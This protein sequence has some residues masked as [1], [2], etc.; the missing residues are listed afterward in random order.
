MRLSFHTYVDYSTTTNVRRAVQLEKV[1][2]IHPWRLFVATFEGILRTTTAVSTGKHEVAANQQKT[3][4][5]TH[6]RVLLPFRAST[7][8]PCNMITAVVVLDVRC[9]LL[10]SAQ[11]QKHGSPWL[12]FKPNKFVLKLPLA[13][14]PPNSPWTSTWRGR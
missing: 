7:T 12:V 5:H 11:I 3:L 13:I 1:Q 10:S 9:A 4:S 2:P 6:T 14:S 8:V